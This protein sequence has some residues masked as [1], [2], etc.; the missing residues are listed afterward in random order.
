[1]AICLAVRQHRIRA[2]SAL[3]LGRFNLLRSIRAEIP[4]API[5]AVIFRAIFAEPRIRVAASAP[6]FLASLALII[7]SYVRAQAPGF[8]LALRKAIV[9]ILLVRKTAILYSVIAP[10]D[11]FLPPPI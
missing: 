5:R 3:G 8:R 6:V 4:A 10:L 11:T 2:Y 9:Q 7:A 1:M